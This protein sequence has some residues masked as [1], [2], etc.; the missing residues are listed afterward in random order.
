MLIVGSLLSSNVTFILLNHWNGRFGNR[1]HQ[2]A[3][4]VTYAKLRSVDFILPSDWEGTKLF[5]TQH[6]KVIG[7]EEFKKELNFSKGIG[8]TND[9]NMK[10]PIVKKYYPD[11]QGIRP[12]GLRGYYY[13]MRPV[14]F[15]TVGAYQDPPT[16]ATTPSIYLPQSR[17]HLIEVF[18]FSDEVK[19]TEAYKYWE[20]RKGTYDVAHLRRDDIASV[21]RNK[22]P[23]RII[24][25]S[26]ISLES[27][28]RA[29]EKFG[30]D[31]DQIEWISDDYTSKWHANRPTAPRYKWNYP[32]GSEYRPGLMF[33]WL[34]DFLRIY[35]A[36]TVFRA[37][38][39][40]SWWPCFLSPY[41]QTYAPLLDKRVVYGRDSLDEVDFEFVKGNYPH[42]TYLGN[43]GEPWQI[44]I[45][46]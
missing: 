15:D 1:M 33:D 19:E 3:Y 5:K 7:N 17:R 22:D 16:V 37:N 14:T 42:W 24:A 44:V 31:K 30:F 45:S 27:Y 25:Y 2:Y 46:R 18:E 36:R 21:E 11:V 13:D 20:A 10:L 28:Y 4:G 6:H 32:E 39:S 41:S 34:D 8:Q 26:V 35:F 38:S 23:K 43:A 9:Y 12:Q 29:F 40:F